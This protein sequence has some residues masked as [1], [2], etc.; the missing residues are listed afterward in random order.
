M[1]WEMYDNLVAITLQKGNL[2]ICFVLIN[3]FIDLYIFQLLS[4]RKKT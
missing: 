3:L 4:F 1:V 2:F